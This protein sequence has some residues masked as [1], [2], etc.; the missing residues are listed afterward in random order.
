[1]RV[2]ISVKTT[3]HD[4]RGRSSTARTTET[5]IVKIRN[6]SCTRHADNNE[7]PLTSSLL[8]YS[9]SHVWGRH[10]ISLPAT[11]PQLGHQYYRSA[12]HGSFPRSS[13]SEHSQEARLAFMAR[14]NPNFKYNPRVSRCVGIRPRKK[15]SGESYSYPTEILDAPCYQTL[16]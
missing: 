8:P 12:M 3:R 10:G 4:S 6:A 15:A 1:M 14:Q 9:L 13:K 7:R 16:S 2:P 5:R 11:S